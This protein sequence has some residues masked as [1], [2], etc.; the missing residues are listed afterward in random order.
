MSGQLFTNT[1]VLL[2]AKANTLDLY[3]LFFLLPLCV[4]FCFIAFVRWGGGG[5]P[6]IWFWSECISGCSTRTSSDSGHF[7]AHAHT[8]TRLK[9]LT[10]CLYR[11]FLP[12]FNELCRH[13][14][15]FSFSSLFALNLHWPPPRRQ[16]FF[17]TWQNVSPAEQLFLPT[18]AVS[19]WEEAYIETMWPSAKVRQ[20]LTFCTSI[21][22]LISFCVKNKIK[23]PQSKSTH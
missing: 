5:T 17:E 11:V 14:A 9:Y 16:W 21:K 7:C 6:F 10:G 23:Y 4:C 15:V 20:V 12:R 8:H 22:E 1:E 3:T 2:Q 19:C 18:G 13:T